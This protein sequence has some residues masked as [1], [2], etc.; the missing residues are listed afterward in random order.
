MLRKLKKAVP[1]VISAVL[2]AA[3]LLDATA[4]A[5]N[6]NIW[7]DTK[8]FT[9][10]KYN[11]NYIKWVEKYS[12]KETKNT[13]SYG[14]S[15]TKKFLDKVEKAFESDDLQISLGFINKD[16]IYSYSLKGDSCKTVV[17]EQDGF[18]VVIYDKNDRGYMFSIKNKL[19]AVFGTDSEINAKWILEIASEFLD[20]NINESDK[21]KIF[22]F[23]SKE[24]LYYYEEFNG[25]GFVFNEN[26][27]PLAAYL[28]G[29]AYC[30]SFKTSVK[31][32]E[33][34]IPKGYKTVSLENFN[35]NL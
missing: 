7:K 30:I 16:V 12:K 21:G 18:A 17:H 5:A 13:V 3:M 27:T 6:S 8:T 29:E 4:F 34:D 22:K 25:S 11:S 23:K 19:C 32:S 31:D 20:F 10:L 35:D 9:S 14:K 24:K 1:A 26:G 15:R 2:C 33:F 28:G